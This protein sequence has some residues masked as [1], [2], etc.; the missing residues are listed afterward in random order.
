MPRGLGYA[1]IV[2]RSVAFLV[3]LGV[4]AAAG[5][6]CEL[7]RTPLR[8]ID[9]AAAAACMSNADCDDG[10]ACTTN[11]CNIESNTCLPPRT[12]DSLC[13][14]NEECDPRHGCRP[15]CDEEACAVRERDPAAC[16]V[17]RCNA[18]GLCESVPH[19]SCTGGADNFCCGDDGSANAGQCITCADDGNACTDVACVNGVCGGVPS[20]LGTCDDGQFCNGPETCVAGACQMTP[21]AQWPCPGSC[22][23]DQNRCEC[24]PDNEA[25]TC[26]NDDP[27]DDT[28]P[29]WSPSDFL[30]ATDCSVDQTRQLRVNGRCEN[31]RCVF[32]M[33][34]Q[35]RT[36]TR[37]RNS[38]VRCGP[39]VN[40][41]FGNC[42]GFSNVCDESGTQERPVFGQF[43][44][45]DRCEMRQIRTE[46]A[47]CSRSSTDGVSCG[48]ASNCSRSS[49]TLCTGTRTVPTCMGG[50]C[51]DLSENCNMGAG[52]PC[53]DGIHCTV[54]ACTNGGVCGSLNSDAR[55]SDGNPCTDNRCD[56]TSGSANSQGCVISNNNDRCSADGVDCTS[57]R[58]SGGS[59]QVESMDDSACPDSPPCRVGVCTSSGCQT[60]PV[61]D[62]ENGGCG[63]GERCCGG[64]C[65]PNSM[66]PAP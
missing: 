47:G 41:S 14:G 58:C 56:P 11:I 16:R 20:E 24:T 2:V 12:D 66:C 5:S 54:N 10:H 63:G 7:I 4:G 17:G 52:T 46:T 9:A 45:R 40:G 29:P 61:P 51:R 48:S 59:C 50:R 53:S 26:V 37:A 60:M 39:D 15:P 13:M 64:M 33:M 27:D 23:F 3:A 35:R 49:D 38:N 36:V 34:E 43:C 18:L 19:E 21:E 28:T 42:G 62:G 1:V 31:S 8:G 6:G 22:D 55:C 44:D 57:E 25:V 65:V 32:D 30:L